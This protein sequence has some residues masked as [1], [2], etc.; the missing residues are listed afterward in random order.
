MSQ[1]NVEVVRALYARFVKG[2]FRASAELFDRHV[3][4]LL[5]PDA[6]EP[7]SMSAS[8]GSR[9]E[10]GGCLRR[11]QSHDGGGGADRRWRQ[12]ARERVSAWVRT[13][14]RRSA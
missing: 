4:F 11:G 14:Q 10:C 2:D 3:S 7:R 5:M 1:E 12:S 6:R 8:K 13:D 9:R